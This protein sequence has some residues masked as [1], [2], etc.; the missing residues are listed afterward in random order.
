M[1]LTTRDRIATLLVALAVLTYGL[2]L[3]GFVGGLTIGSVAIAVLALGVLASASAVVPGFMELLHG[4]RVY[5][6]VASLL[7]LAA[8][9]SGILTVVNS[10]EVTLATLVIATVVLWA[11]ATVRHAT[12]HQGRA[13]AVG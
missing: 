3:T 1:N 12:V 10:T 6:A 8:F 5:L 9:A 13:P 7:G 2:W 11:V 4:S